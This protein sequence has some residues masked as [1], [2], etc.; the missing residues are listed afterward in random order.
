MGM[1]CGRK[2]RKHECTGTFDIVLGSSG[3]NLSAVATPRPARRDEHVVSSTPNADTDG[4]NQTKHPLG[5]SMFDE[6]SKADI[7]RSARKSLGD[8]FYFQKKAKRGAHIDVWW[9]Y[10]DGGLTLL[11]PYILS[12]RRNWNN[13]KLRVF[14][15][16]NKDDELESEQLNMAGMLA[17]FRIDYS[18]LQ[19]V[20]NVS[21]KPQDTTQRFFDSLIEGFRVPKTTSDS[22]R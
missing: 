21:S 2:G 7:Y 9:L 8:L 6:H 22:G 5:G 13:C 11:L 16:A 14:A 18:D 15:L 1:L 3:S 20:S 12:T 10:D 17:K 4:H 19:I